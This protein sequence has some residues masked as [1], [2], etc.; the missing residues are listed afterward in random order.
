MIQRYFTL[1]ICLFS[2]AVSHAQDSTALNVELF[3]QFHRGDVRYSG[4]W[5]YIDG[6]GNEYALLGTRTGVAAYT[7]DDAMEIEEVGFVSGPASNWREITVIDSFAY[8]TTEGSSDTTGMQVIDLQ[9]LPDSLHLLT[10][11]SETFTRG[12]IIQRNV[13]SD[14]AYVF[15]NGTSSTEGV[16]I[17]NVTNPADPVEIGRYEPGYYIHDCHVKNDLL[18]GCAFYEGVIDIVDISDKTNPVLIAQIDDPTG[19][20]HS[21][22]MTED[23]RFL[24]V[25]SEQDGL[26]SRI[27]NIED[28]GNIYEVARYTANPLS[29]VHNPYI[30]GDFCYMSHNT[31]GLRVLDIVDPELPVEVGFYDTFDGPSGGFSGLWSACPFYPSGKIIGG[32]REDGLYIWT[33][34]NTYAGRIYGLVKDSITGAILENVELIVLE[35]QDTLLQEMNGTFKWGNLTGQYQI[36]AKKEGYF[37]KFESI[38]LN[39]EDS[40]GI[41]IELVPDTG[42]STENLSSITIPKLKIAPNPF[43]NSTSVDLTNFPNAHFL[44]IIDSNGRHLQTYSVENQQYVTILKDGLPLG[45]YIFQLVNDSGKVLATAQVLIQ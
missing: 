25:C 10:T 31:E 22:W 37:S 39:E 38:D 30:R 27:Y 12:H 26:P 16:H 34:N 24:V 8:V 40:L 44:N 19:R 9:Y 33:F 20:T 15:V 13:Y 35:T 5:A 14:S 32:N 4:S 45:N 18:F 29:L 3:G 2:F 1:F 21:C 23:D 17:L 11:Y 42:V 43:S 36:S 6:D 28:F 7:I 41:V